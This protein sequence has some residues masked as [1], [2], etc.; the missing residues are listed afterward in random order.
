MTVLIEEFEIIDKI[1]WELGTIELTSHGIVQFIPLEGI[2]G[3]TMEQLE[4][5]FSHLMNITKGT[6]KP[7][8]S[9][10]VNMTGPLSTEAKVYVGKNCHKFATA[11]AITERHPITRFIAHSI[12]YLHRPEIPMKLFKNKQ[13]A[14]DWLRVQQ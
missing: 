1:Q 14:Y 11:F 2:T 4:L 13:T 5:M 8:L 9:H 3:I 6:P 7:F 10:N 12:M